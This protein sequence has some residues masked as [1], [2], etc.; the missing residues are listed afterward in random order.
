[1]SIPYF[2]PSISFGKTSNDIFL[3]HHSISNDIVLCMRLHDY[4]TSLAI[5]ER[6]A[7]AKRCGTSLGFLKLLAYG[8]KPCSPELAVAID[9]ETSGAVSFEEL[10]PSPKM[11]WAYLRQKFGATNPSASQC[12]SSSI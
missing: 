9:R 2:P 1:M 6:D 10:C 4:I 8:R 5:K 3:L 12:S 7:F 11:D